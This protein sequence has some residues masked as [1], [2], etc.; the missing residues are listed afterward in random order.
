MKWLFSHFFFR[1]PNLG[2]ESFR[3]NSSEKSDRKSHA[4]FCR[5]R[6]YLATY[7]KPENRE[8]KRRF[9]GNSWFSDF[10]DDFF[11]IFRFIPIL[12]WFYY[13]YSRCAEVS[14]KNTENAQLFRNFRTKPGKIF[15]EISR[16][17]F[18]PT[19][20]FFRNF[21]ISGNLDQIS[22]KFT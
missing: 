6:L 5:N 2:R 10:R 4:K 19:V 18:F 22:S 8:K 7:R 12:P 11:E 15:P 1:I 13:V 3:G 20:F 17:F 21:R 16:F 9:S 14:V